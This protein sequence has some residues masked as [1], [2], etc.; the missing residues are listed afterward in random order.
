MSPIIE[1]FP[2]EPH[3]ERVIIFP[4]KPKTLSL[5]GIDIDSEASE[6]VNTGIIIALGPLA[7]SQTTLKTGDR[8]MFEKFAGQP[9]HW[10]GVD[11][12]RMQVNDILFTI[13]SKLPS[14]G[15]TLRSV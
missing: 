3:F 14:D 8:V 5:G 1:S 13:H 6:K 15:S 11:Y 12:I 9:L 7:K 10:D 2:L 4:D